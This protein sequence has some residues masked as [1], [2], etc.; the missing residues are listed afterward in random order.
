MSYR[1]HQEDGISMLVLVRVTFVTLLS[2]VVVVVV[3]VVE[4]RR[5]II[6]KIEKSDTFCKDWNLIIAVKLDL[7]PLYATVV[8]NLILCSIL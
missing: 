8:L 5:K 7:S 6:E 1:I 4:I 3:V 2:L